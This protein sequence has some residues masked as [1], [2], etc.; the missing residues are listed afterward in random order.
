MQAETTAKIQQGNLKHNV[1]VAQQQEL[2]GMRSELKRAST[3]TDMAIKAE[4][5]LNATMKE[6]MSL[7]KMNAVTQAQLR[8]KEEAEKAKMA[9]N[10]KDD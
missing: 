2:A 9:S 1:K 6:R 5:D 10:D 4:K 3:L 7:T 8:A